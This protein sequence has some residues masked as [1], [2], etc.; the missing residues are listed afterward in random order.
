MISFL[1]NFSTDG[2]ASRNRKQNRR[3]RVKTVLAT[4]KNLLKHFMF[5]EKETQIIVFFLVTDEILLWLIW[6]VKWQI[7]SVCDVFMFELN[8]F[9]RI[10]SSYRQNRYTWF[11][12]SCSQRCPSI[13][14]E[15]ID[16]HWW[17]KNQETY[18]YICKYIFLFFKLL[19]SHKKGEK[20]FCQDFFLN[21][22]QNKIG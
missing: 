1:R 19:L 6:T 12:N 16:S 14:V 22:D 21:I 13:G 3:K 17:N 4:V 5:S 7:A 9:I 8:I 11:T 2:R 20:S 10:S 18:I 15:T